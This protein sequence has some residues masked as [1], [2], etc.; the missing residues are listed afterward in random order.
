MQFEGKRNQ[1]KFVD[2]YLYWE[3][4]KTPPA[5]MD[6]KL[7]LTFSDN[8]GIFLGEHKM[9]REQYHGQRVCSV[10]HTGPVRMHA[11]VDMGP[12]RPLESFVFTFH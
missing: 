5:F 11:L 12:D 8:K 10:A 1:D 6:R 3:K 7:T 4:S 2:I 9:V